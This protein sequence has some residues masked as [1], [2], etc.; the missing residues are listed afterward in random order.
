MFVPII[1]L[2]MGSA[3]GNVK[4]ELPPLNNYLNSKFQMM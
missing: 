4:V 2:G 3:L 1:I